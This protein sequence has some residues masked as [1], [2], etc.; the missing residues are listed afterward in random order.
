MLTLLVPCLAEN[1]IRPFTIGRKN[2]LF[3]GSPKGVAAS[4]A[5][6]SLV[7]TAK[8]NGLSPHRYLEYI[9]GDLPG[10][11]FRQY[12]EILDDYLPWHPDI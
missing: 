7:E 6:Y 4:A 9:L 5:I 8:T 11:P 1:S 2:W 12:P 10:V 3:S